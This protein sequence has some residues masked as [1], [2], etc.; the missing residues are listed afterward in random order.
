MVAVH[1]L[2]RFGA[3][4]DVAANGLE[5]VEALSRIR[6]DLVLMDCQM[7]EMDGYAATRAIRDAEAASGL[8]TPIV[9]MTANAMQG[10]REK[11][12]QAGMD[13]YLAKPVKGAE[14]KAML[15]RWLARGEGS[16]ESPLDAA[17]F[18]TLREVD[19][20]GSDGFLQELIAKFVDEEAPS[21]LHA[22]R[23]SVTAADAVALARAAHSLKGSAGTLGATGMVSLCLQIEA[24]GKAG[25]LEGAAGL[26]DRLEAEF[27]R[28]REGL[29][30]ERERGSQRR[31]AA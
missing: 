26:L 3:Q 1:M 31:S 18:A 9:A 12:L 19:A 10:D 20:E 28:V 24:R 8:R 27:R 23:Q 7:P 25:S 17:R 4:A 30:I 5:A 13:D 15:D 2:R 14:L 22:L 6:Y 21:R 16:T 29:G 11:C